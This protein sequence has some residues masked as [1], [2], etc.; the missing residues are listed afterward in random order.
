LIKPIKILKKP[1]GL[2]RFWFY[3]KKTKKKPSLNRENQA[4]TKKNQ[5]KTGKTESNWFEPVFTLKN[6]TGSKPV[7]LIQFQLS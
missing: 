2:V 3:K 4:K 6:Q 1:A 7:G 5:A